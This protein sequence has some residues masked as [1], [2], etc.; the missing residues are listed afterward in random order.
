MVRRE[1]KACADVGRRQIGEVIKELLDRHA[2]GKVLQDIPDRDP[3]AANARLAAPFA[4]LECDMPLPIHAPSVGR[5]CLPV[6]ASEAITSCPQ[7]LFVSKRSLGCCE[8]VLGVLVVGTQEEHV[9]GVLAQQ[10]PVPLRHCFVGLIQQ[11][12]N[13]PLDPLAW[14]GRTA[15]QP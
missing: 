7:H 15:L 3:K 14:H 4:R 10:R 9:L 5:A 13:M 12:V 2:S 1:G 6:N 11:P 8:E